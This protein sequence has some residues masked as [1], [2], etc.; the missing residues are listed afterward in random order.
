MAAVADAARHGRL[1]ARPARRDRGRA[2]VRD[3]VAA[4]GLHGVHR[5]DRLGGARPGRALELAGVLRRRDV[6]RQGVRRHGHDGGHPLVAARHA[7]ALP[8]T[9][10][11]A[12]ALDAGELA[13]PVDR[14]VDLRAQWLGRPGLLL[15]A[16][17]HLPPLPGL[18]RHPAGVV[19]GAAGAVDQAAARRAGGRTHRPA[20]A[21][22]AAAR[23]DRPVRGD[24]PGPPAHPV[25]DARG[26]R[27][28]GA[29]GPLRA[30]RPADPVRGPGRRL[31]LV[32]RGALLVGPL[33]RAVRRARRRRRQRVVVGLRT[34]PGRQ[35]GPQ[36]RP[37]RAR[38]AHAAA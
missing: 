32:P 22:G 12:D 16:G 38:A 9:D 31:G 2:A 29:R 13:R 11:P 24:G 35:F 1:A 36:T 20:P 28:P 23:P 21:G 17:L 33:R 37:L 7:T 19:P 10:V 15:P 5:Q 3:G 27:G 4:P 6:R 34:Y 26:P 25:R 14:T 30:A 18:R 8:G